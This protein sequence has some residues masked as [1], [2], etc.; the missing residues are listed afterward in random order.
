MPCDFLPFCVTGWVLVSVE[1]LGWFIKHSLLVYKVCTTDVVS[2][3]VLPWYSWHLILPESCQVF[4]VTASCRLASYPGI[5]GI[6]YFQLSRARI[7]KAHTLPTNRCLLSIAF[8]LSWSFHELHSHRDQR[9]FLL[10]TPPCSFWM[11]SFSVQ[12]SL[13]KASTSPFHLG[14]INNGSGWNRSLRTNCEVHFCL[15]LVCIMWPGH[16][17]NFRDSGDV[18]LVQRGPAIQFWH[19]M[20]NNGKNRH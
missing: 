5:R 7:Y 2:P 15:G 17:W 6:S 16:T 3:S 18:T 13:A 9:F 14:G 1:V 8:W 11:K 10:C 20:R 4:K 12:N 19:L